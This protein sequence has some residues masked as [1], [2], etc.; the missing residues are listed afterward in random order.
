MKKKEKKEK[1]IKKEKEVM[2]ESVAAQ[3]VETVD[4][5]AENVSLNDKYVRLAAEFENFKK[6]MQK[7]KEDYYD[8]G[9]NF[10]PFS[11]TE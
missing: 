6:R 7:E 11:I 5:V 1:K 2:P 9:T 4:L 10:N 3:E 8:E